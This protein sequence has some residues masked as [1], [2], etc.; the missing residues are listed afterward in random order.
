[1]V[2]TIKSSGLIAAT[3]NL[4]LWRFHLPHPSSSIPCS[5]SHFL[6]LSALG[7]SVKWCVLGVRHPKR[8]G[9]SK[10]CLLTEKVLHK[11]LLMKM[12]KIRA[13]QGNYSK[14]HFHHAW[15]NFTQIMEGGKLKSTCSVIAVCLLSMSGCGKL[16][17]P[18]T[19]TFDVSIE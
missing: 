19:T 17:F 7:R 16:L 18:R 2:I 12:K 3:I 8:R 5:S 1:M 11:V 10:R 6:P 14:I 4:H 13:C 15:S 9:V